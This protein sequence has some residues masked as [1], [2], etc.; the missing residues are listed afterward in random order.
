MIFKNYYKILGLTK[1]TKSTQ[2]EIKSAYREQ[3]KNI[4]QM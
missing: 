3:A 1:N 4:I 2:E